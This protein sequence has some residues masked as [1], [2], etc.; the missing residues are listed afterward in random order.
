MKQ[1]D[2]LGM[3]RSAVLEGPYRYSLTRDWHPIDQEP[4]VVLWVMLN[5]S[6]ADAYDDDA[7][8]RRIRGFTERWGY[9]CAVVVN[10]YALRSTD[11]RALAVATDPIGPGNDATIALAARLAHR[12]VC[13]WGDSLPPGAET[14]I[15]FVLS[16]LRG[17][18]ALKRGATGMVTLGFTAA[19]QPR[20]PV[21]LAYDTP[22]VPMSG[23][24]APSKPSRKKKPS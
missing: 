9:D 18:I 14:R 5:P 21:R 3:R 19:G 16:I 23:S 7:T 22:L 11:P 2:M 1:L 4:R 17:A 6:T 8:I 12:I 24:A 20:H 15:D 10:L 13:A